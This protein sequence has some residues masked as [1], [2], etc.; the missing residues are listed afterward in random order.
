MTRISESIQIG[1]APTEV[2]RFCH[3]L[4]RRPEWDERVDRI[5]LQG[6]SNVLRNGA[7]VRVDSHAARGLPYSWE[8]EYTQFRS[9]RGSTVRIMETARVSNLN[10]GGSEEWQF[11]PAEGGTCFTIIWTYE[12]RGLLGRMLDP[13][14]RRAANRRA[15]RH[16]LQRAKA[17]IEAR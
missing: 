13:L 2:F 10:P 11:E 8:G 9:P 4:K 1:A 5:E 7:L 3:D 14:G 6:F 15:I 12:P 17:Q 16:S